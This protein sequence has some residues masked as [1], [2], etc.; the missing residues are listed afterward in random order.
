MY[1]ANGT[2]QNRTGRKMHSGLFVVVVVVVVL[3][4]LGD[5]IYLHET[6]CKS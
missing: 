1:T 4:S 6:S 3:R 2:E 5:G